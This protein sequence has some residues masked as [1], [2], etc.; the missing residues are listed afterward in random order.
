MARQYNQIVKLTGTLGGL[1][2][3][4]SSLDGFLVRQKSSLDSAR[5]R[6]DPAFIRTR[7]NASEFGNAVRAGTLL[8]RALRQAL[9][10]ARDGRLNA[11]MNR[12]MM[13]AKDFDVVNN[14]GE[15]RAGEG[16]R[17][18]EA[19]E[20]LH[21]FEFNSRASLEQVLLRSFDTDPEG[22]IIR[23]SGFQPATQIKWPADATHCSFEEVLTHVHFDTE[24]SVTEFSEAASFSRK[25]ESIQDLNL[26]AAV[27]PMEE[28]IQLQLLL[29]QFVQEINGHQ[30]PLWG[31]SSNVLTVVSA[32]GL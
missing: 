1:S 10:L 13:R 2:F 28:G 7:E 31:R 17:H 9:P 32:V 5:V 15:R 30:Y 24:K 25:D 20:L 3:Y 27:V 6:R 23:I 8:R 22:G 12:L 18:A 16:F 11:R 21:G 4:H 19:V 14:R 26:A 29:L